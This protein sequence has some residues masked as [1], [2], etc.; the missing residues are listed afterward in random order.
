[1]GNGNN[2]ESTSPECMTDEA[3]CEIQSQIDRLDDN[4]HVEYPAADTPIGG[5]QRVR[6]EVPEPWSV[7]TVGAQ[8]WNAT[9]GVPIGPGGIALGTSANFGA[10]ITGRSCFNS[11]GVTIVHSTESMRLLTQT[12]LGIASDL[13]LRLGSRSRNVEITAGGVTPFNPRFSV[14][15][16]TEVPDA[17]DVDT[18]SPRSTTESARETAAK[19]WLAVDTVS[20]ARTVASFL[21]DFKKVGAGIADGSWATRVSELINLCKNFYSVRD[22][23]L[24]AAIAAA[25]ARAGMIGIDRNESE[26]PKV[27]VHGEGGV[28]LTSP[29]AVQAF[30][31]QISFLGSKTASLGGITKVSVKSM[32]LAGVYGAL[33]ASLSSEGPVAVKSS[34][35]TAVLAGKCAE[36]SGKEIATLKS[37]SKVAVSAGQELGL[38]A[39]ETAVAGEAYLGLSSSELIQAEAPRIES[40]ARREQTVSS[41]Q[42][43]LIKAGQRVTVGRADEG[44]N[45]LTTGMQ[46]ESGKI[47]FDTGTRHTVVTIE[48]DSLRAFGLRARSGEFSV[49]GLVVRR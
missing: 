31:K 43:V 47:T 29:T 23:G 49:H 28:D 41:G 11:Y 13:E 42:T 7:L 46:I 3:L 10:Q 6:I 27:K 12:D 24:A 33:M 19:I 4:I 16:P 18:A 48:R 15:P 17:P 38:V 5:A 22:A 37:D 36:V 32:G 9:D 30:A 20:A 14:S 34:A 25:D 44:S 1:M 39:K 26:S 35:S 45:S 8:G 2:G 21:R 40:L